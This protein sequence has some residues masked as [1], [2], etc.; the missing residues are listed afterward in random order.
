LVRTF[1]VGIGRFSPLVTKHCI[2]SLMVCCHE[3]PRSIARTL[4]GLLQTLALHITNPTISLHILEFLVGTGRI[5]RIHEN[6]TP[7]EFL[8]VFQ[9][10]VKYLQH[11]HATARERTEIPELEARML[12]YVVHLAY[13]ALTVWFL[14]VRLE[15][16][17]SN[18]AWIVRQ[19]ILAHNSQELDGQ[20]LAFIDMLERFS[21]S[22]TALKKYPD[23]VEVEGLGQYKKN[24]V[25]GRSIQTAQVARLDGLVKITVRKA[26]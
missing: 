12:Q 18:V 13:E 25:V 8:N 19:L 4:S 7:E 3:F 23:A 2:H 20:A 1:E 6:F 16:R 5:P 15:N 21:F 14:A 24:W 17:R 11:S 26:V 9:V 22:D 10:A